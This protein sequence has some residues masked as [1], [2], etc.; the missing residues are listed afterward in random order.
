M[1]FERIFPINCV[2]SNRGIDQKLIDINED[3]TNRTKRFVLFPEFELWMND[4][5]YLHHP[6]EFLYWISNYY[7]QSIPT[8]SIQFY[9]HQIIDDINQYIKHQIISVE[10]AQLANQSN[11]NYNFFDYHICPNA[12]PN[13]TI[14]DVENIEPMLIYPIEII[15][16]NRYRAN[17]GMSIDRE[18]N[19]PRS[20]MKFNTHH[21]FLLY[22]DF[23]YDPVIYTC[24]SDAGPCA[25]DLYSVMLHETL[26]GFGIEVKF[27][28]KEKFILFVN[29]MFVFSIPKEI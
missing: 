26:H 8:D 9:I 19:S 6:K 11:F 21:Q 4:W 24:T 10:Q 7:P 17:G 14:D 13:A 23:Q 1:R 5:R 2:H 20:H 22:N 28:E 27:I 16:E 12:D 18:T 3:V 25:I 15:Q 29:R